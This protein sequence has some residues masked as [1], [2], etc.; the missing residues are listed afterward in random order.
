MTDEDRAR[1]AIVIGLRRTAGISR[2][3]LRDRFRFTPEEL[4]ATE[5]KRHIELGNLTDDG[6]QIQ[7]TTEGRY[8]ADSVVMDFL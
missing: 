5:L 3:H 2:Q 1:E 4:A 6:D 8:V 7:L